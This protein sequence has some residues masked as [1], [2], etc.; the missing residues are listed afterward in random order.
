MLLIDNM[1]NS[2]SIV[3]PHGVSMLA[4]P[5]GS[6][7]T[8]AALAFRGGSFFDVRQFAATPVLVRHPEGD[9]LIDA[10][11]GRDFDGHLRML[12]PTNGRRTRWGC[13][14]STS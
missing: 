12:P 2:E 7:A 13:R 5:T 6:Y 9:L 10:G 3:H 11:F 14:A 1:T 4:L 8:R